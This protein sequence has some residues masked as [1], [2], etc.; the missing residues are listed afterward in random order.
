MNG[1]P[2]I[3]LAAVKIG[4]LLKNSTTVNEIN[5]IASSV[6]AFGCEEF[7]IEGVTSVRAKWIFD[8]LMTLFKQSLPDAEKQA[9]ARSFLDNITPA[10]ERAQVFQVLIDTGILPAETSL[11]VVTGASSADDDTTES[12]LLQL[13]FRPE[14]LEKVPVD[15]GML[16]VLVSRMREA[17]ACLE[18]KAH[19]AAVILSG[20]VLEGM[21][22]GFGSRHPERVNRAF[23]AR[24]NRA[25][26]GFPEWKLREWIDVLGHLG[27]LSPNVEKFGHA[28]REFRNYVHPAEQL[29]NQ[30]SPDHHT[31]RICFQVVVA[32]VEDL[33]R[34][35]AAL[36]QGSPP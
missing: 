27:D 28:V 35:E 6:F 25:P 17:Q 31:A 5:R 4:D 30:F 13:V 34:A 26:K 18:V 19:L 2:Q 20:S 10:D 32:A 12:T 23:T 3:K 16:P 7:P 33:T 21:C 8:W 22:L 14:L 29:A 9:L 15:S 1:K 11:P 36:S 24:F